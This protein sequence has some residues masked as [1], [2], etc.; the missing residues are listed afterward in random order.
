LITLTGWGAIG[1]V[2]RLLYCGVWFGLPFGD[3]GLVDLL[4]Y[5]ELGLVI[6]LDHGLLFVVVGVV[7]RLVQD[8]TDEA[9][10]DEG[11]R[12]LYHG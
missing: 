9:V 4:E 12:F 5:V 6:T 1:V 3:D 2:D 10:G 7:L 8:E 11:P